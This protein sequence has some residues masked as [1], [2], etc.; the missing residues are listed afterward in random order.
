M[1]P[2]PTNQPQPAKKKPTYT[3]NSILESLRDL[4]SG[5]GKSVAKDVVG[6]VASDAL[7]SLFGQIGR[8]SCRERV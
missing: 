4:G 7:T 3:N 1:Q 8:A 6:T 2:L 5:V